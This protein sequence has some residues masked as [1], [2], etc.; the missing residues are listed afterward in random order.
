M[1]GLVVDSG[2]MIGN[3]SPVHQIERKKTISSFII[4]GP[5][6]PRTIFFS[7]LP[8]VVDWLNLK[9]IAVKISKCY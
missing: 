4:T 7:K 5:L 3:K 8:Y 9:F 2:A 1:K 6:I